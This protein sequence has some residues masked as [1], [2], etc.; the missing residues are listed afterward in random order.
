[1]VSMR[2]PG[3]LPLSYGRLRPISLIALFL[4][5]LVLGLAASVFYLLPRLTGTALVFE[6][7]LNRALPLL[8]L[9][10]AGGLVIVG[11]GWGDGREP[12][13]LPWWWDVPVLGLTALALGPTVFTISNR[14]SGMVYPSLW[15]AISATLWLPALYLAGNLPFLSSLANTLS[16]AMFTAGFVNVWAVGLA[17]GAAYYVVPKVSRQPLANRQ[18][19]RVGL[20]SLLFGGVW[21]GPAQ[22]AAGPQ[23]DW[24]GAVAAVLGLALP[25][26]SLATTTNL[27]MT[28]GSKWPEIWRQPVLASALAGS[29][30][31]TLGSLFA[32]LAGFRS[33][34]VLVGFTVFWEGVGVLLLAGIALLFAAFAWQAVPNLVGRSVDD[35]VSKVIRRLSLGGVGTG[36]LLALSGYTAGISW[37]GAAFTGAFD[38][39]GAGWSSGMGLAGILS[40]LAL[41]VSIYLVWGLVTLALSI[42]RALTSGRATVQEVLVLKES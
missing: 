29:G 33:A 10:I 13:A 21:M 12:F 37:S 38:S 14:T 19:A 11:L 7:Q 36:V 35:P 24:L 22:L 6:K 40:G 17:T 18:L 42:Y 4:G 27:A 2:F 31:I 3:L 41:A 5:W 26:S 32:A 39:I 15:F 30:L 8:V 16:D 25:I 20:W 23:P 34:S 1:M 28:V 9:V